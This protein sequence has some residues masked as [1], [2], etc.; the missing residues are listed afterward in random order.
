MKVNSQ[1][2]RNTLKSLDNTMCNCWHKEYIHMELHGIVKVM[3]NDQDL[4]K[5]YWN[6]VSCK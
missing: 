6:L 5:L 4:E 1:T 3:G 2:W